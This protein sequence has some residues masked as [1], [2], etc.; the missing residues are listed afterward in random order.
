MSRINGN[1]ATGDRGAQG[2]TSKNSLTN[3]QISPPPQ[4]SPWVRT[5]TETLCSLR[6]KF[7]ACFARLDHRSRQP[8]KIKIHLDLV[9]AA[10]DIDPVNIGRALKYYTGAISYLSQCLEGSVRVEL[11]GQPSGTVSVKE[12]AHAKLLFDKIKG[13]RKPTPPP[14]QASPPRKLSL[15]DLKAAARKRAGGGL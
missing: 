14:A 8:L 4:G 13:R 3:S 12:A 7:P 5:A 15:D 11:T 2:S 9:A 6:A 1:P 10:P